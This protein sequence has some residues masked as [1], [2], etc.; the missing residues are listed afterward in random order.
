[1]GRLVVATCVGVAGKV[2]E[3]GG[4]SVHT[5]VAV[6]AGTGVALGGSG[7][8][9]AGCGLGVEVA[10]GRTVGSGVPSPGS[11]MPWRAQARVVASNDAATQRH[12]HDLIACV[13]TA[14]IPL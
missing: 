4:T 2:G 8:A 9:V 6:T 12:G 13:D 14:G 1:M 3:A 7:V 11:T 5:D 10:G